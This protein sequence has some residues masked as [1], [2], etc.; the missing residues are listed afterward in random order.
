MRIAWSYSEESGLLL[1]KRRTWHTESGTALLWNWMVID[2]RCITRR[3]GYWALDEDWMRHQ[4]Y[5]TSAFGIIHIL[6][7]RRRKTRTTYLLSHGV[8]NTG[9]VGTAYGLH[10]Y[11][12]WDYTYTLARCWKRRSNPGTAGRDSFIN[13]DG[14]TYRYGYCIIDNGT[15]GCRKSG[16]NRPL[17]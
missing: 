11:V 4:A 3:F 5:G 8:S 6:L 15:L 2:F 14:Q 1:Y 12:V 13:G 7:A 9:H 17:M 10:H 16:Y